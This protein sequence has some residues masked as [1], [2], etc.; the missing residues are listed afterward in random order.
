MPDIDNISHDRIQLV[1]KDEE[2]VS[3][4]EITYCISG[5]NYKNRV[6]AKK[7]INIK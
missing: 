4:P 7:V 6:K 3:Q 5:C 2:S 1:S